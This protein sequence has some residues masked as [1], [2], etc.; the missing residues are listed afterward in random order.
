M[1][2]S[3][4]SVN[5]YLAQGFMHQRLHLGF[6]T[7]ICHSSTK[8][9]PECSIV[10]DSVLSMDIY[11]WWHPKYP[12]SDN[13]LPSIMRDEELLPLLREDFF[14]SKNGDNHL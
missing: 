9:V 12:H 5:V 1:G 11:D 10:I 7:G 6:N 14:T 2:M 3:L 13:K 8:I 4:S